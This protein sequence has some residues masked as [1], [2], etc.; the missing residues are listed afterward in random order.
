MRGVM[1]HAKRFVRKST[2]IV[3]DPSDVQKPYAKKMRYLAKEWDG[4]QVEWGTGHLW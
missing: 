3:I 2:L 1:E 4:S